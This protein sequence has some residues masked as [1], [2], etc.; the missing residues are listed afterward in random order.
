[1]PRVEGRI[2]INEVHRFSRQ[3]AQH[4]EVIAKVNGV[5]RHE[6]ILAEVAK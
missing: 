2:N 3:A 1:M 6:V 5:L 4:G